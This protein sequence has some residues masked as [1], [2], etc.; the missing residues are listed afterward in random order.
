M[1]NDEEKLEI[2]SS[3]ENIDDISK[4]STIYILSKLL[5]EV[6]SACLKRLFPFVTHNKRM[7]TEKIKLYELVKDRINVRNVSVFFHLAVIF[8]LKSFSRMTLNFMQRWLTAVVDDGDFLE[9]SHF[10]VSKV[11]ASFYGSKFTPEL[12]GF[13]FFTR[14]KD[15]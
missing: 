5:A 14:P 8:N 9:L 7:R 13:T 2:S 10:H 15:G 4:Y 12:R 1:L 6:V 11:L 3:N